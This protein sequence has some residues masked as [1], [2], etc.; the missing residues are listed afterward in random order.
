MISQS[1]PL[2][3]NENILLSCSVESPP[4]PLSVS[5]GATA[6]RI[7]H[8]TLALNLSRRAPNSCK[9]FTSNHE[10]NGL[11]SIFYTSLRRMRF[12]TV[13]C[14]KVLSSVR[15]AKPLNKG[16]STCLVPLNLTAIKKSK[17]ANAFIVV[18]HKDK[19]QSNTFCIFWRLGNWI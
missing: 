9:K 6:L 13:I 2:K 16:E 17:D 14:S 1:A 3:S 15:T 18:Y 7:F 10:W 12:L 4:L 5:V 8:L 11:V 19:V